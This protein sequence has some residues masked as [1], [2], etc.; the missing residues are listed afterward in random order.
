MLSFN[1]EGRVLVLPQLN[2]PDFVDFSQKPL[3]IWKNG[4]KVNRGR[5]RQGSGEGGR[6]SCYYNI[7]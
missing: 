1:A 2:V 5:E 7:K 3:L 4:W 6:E